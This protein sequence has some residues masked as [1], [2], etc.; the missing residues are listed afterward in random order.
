[1]LHFVLMTQFP[2][3][4]VTSAISA[5]WLLM[6]VQ[7]NIEARSCKQCC[8]GQAIMIAYSACKFVAL[9]IQH[10]KRKHHTVICGLPDCT[11][12]LHI[13]S[14]QQKFGRK[15]NNTKC[16]FWLSVQLLFKIFFVIG[17]IKRD[18]MTTVHTALCGVSVVLCRVSV[19]LCGVSVVLGR[20]N[21]TCVLSTD[22]RKYSN[23]KC[24]EIVTDR[25]T[26]WRS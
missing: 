14:K 20:F 2:A 15:S 10:A 9:V 7:R 22:L 1:M 5:M 17:T 24:H 8:S 23:T 19:V 12:F 4:V 11:V 25:R 13:I 21:G 6:Y 26:A 3:H 18:V 16:A